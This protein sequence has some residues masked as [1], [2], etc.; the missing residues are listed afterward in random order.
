MSND[1]VVVC[2]RQPV[3]ELLRAARRPVKRLLC[4]AREGKTLADIVALAGERG[5]RVEQAD[6]AAVAKLAGGAH[7]QGVAA[8]TVPLPLLA[9]DELWPRL[10]E[11]QPALLIADEVQDP[12][13]VGSLI[14]SA[15]TLG[16][17]AL[18]IP[19]RRS[20]GLTPAAERAA[21]GA[22]EHLPVVAVGNTAAAMLTLREHGIW[23]VGTVVDGGQSLWQTD[24][25]GP[26]AV[27]VGNEAD[28]LRRL[29]RDRCD[30]LVTI[31]RGGLTDSLNVATAATAVM[32]EVMR[33]RAVGPPPRPGRKP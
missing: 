6:D 20:A 17:H 13:N 11:Q 5:V 31:P 3:R 1:P 33:Q 25:T 26:T 9:L 22:A 7:H 19:E 23:L 27:L 30:L 18:L 28:G 14:R 24:L 8:V 12:Q 21:S 32:A 2:G 10:G 16:F 15:E 4:S 29:V